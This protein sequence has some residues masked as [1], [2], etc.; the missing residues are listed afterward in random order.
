MKVGVLVIAT[1]R[2][3]EL[4]A[5][6]HASMKRYLLAGTPHD[7]RYF[8]FTDAPAALAA[9]PGV[10]CIE[11][12]WRPW[13]GPSLLRY[14]LFLQHERLLSEVDY[15]LH[16][17]AD[18]RFVAP[19][20][21]E[22]LGELVATISPVAHDKRRPRFPYENRVASAAYVPPR[23]GKRYYAGAFN[24]GETGRFLEMARAI[25][26]MTDADGRRGIV[27]RCNDES[28]LNKYL[29]DHPPTVTLSP[30]YCYPES[31]RLPFTPKVLCL[32]KNHAAMRSAVEKE[33][34]PKPPPPAD[35]G[36][37]RFVVVV[38]SY[39]NRPWVE[40]CLDSIFA[41]DHPRFRVSYHDDLSSDG[42]ADLVESY[43]ARR[44]IGERLSLVRNRSKRFPAG[45]I[46]GAAHAADDDEIVVTLDGDDCFAHPGVL[47]HLDRLYQDPE[48][49]LTYGQF[50][51]RGSKRVG[52]AAPL[53]A[54]AIQRNA[55]RRHPWV[56][57]HLRT[58][59][60]WLYKRIKLHDLIHRGNFISAAGDMALMLPMAEMA[61]R[62]V[63]FVPEVLYV[64]NEG[65]PLSDAKVHRVEQR[66]CDRHVRSRPPYSPLAE[67]PAPL[68]AALPE[69]ALVAL[70]FD[71]PL[72]LFALLE[73]LERNAVQL[74]PITVIARA[75]RPE[76]RASYAEV[77][78]RFP[79]VRF[80]FQEAAPHDFAK[81]VG[82]A[83]SS[84]GS[85]HVVFAVDDIVVTRPIAFGECARALDRTGA[86]G[87][88]L[89]M[90]THLRR[91]YPV[92]KPQSVPPYLEA[93]PGV[94]A[95][96][97]AAGE[98][99]WRYP[100]TLDMTIYRTQEIR[101][102]FA[103]LSFRSPN[104]LEAA[105]ARRARLDRV[106]LFFAE[107]R[108][109]NLPLNRVQ[110]DFENRAMSTLTAEDLL[111][112]FRAGLKLDI[113]PLQGVLNES[114]HIDY[115]PRFVPR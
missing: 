12:P 48:V 82:E 76:H 99:D 22:I 68:P 90:G 33:P 64:Y 10:T 83:V 39:N 21:E 88:F 62:R 67:R 104:T 31:W 24:G 77:G 63:R 103:A 73:S 106:G 59:Y 100:N 18:M 53:P 20:G 109:V 80:L 11:E 96:E 19:V 84:A 89:R 56:L 45:N 8:V 27:A 50:V 34:E 13:P 44:G 55:L 25:R 32:D 51:Y 4:V 47:A 79:A 78:Q 113:A 97:F 98:L 107:A 115:E 38:P 36:P 9:S 49:W 28:Y 5:P 70:T 105:W 37:R 15:L 26:D 111:D 30:E 75:S 72:Q 57:T 91:S 86:H 40:E 101:A 16:C 6:L 43:V 2:Y 112:R 71:R 42:T 1:G 60:A 74:G 94:L 65:N 95:W 66:E 110:N 14:H 29:C 23:A 69:V 114:A 93:L 102:A 61:A 81:L 92:N 85:P 52:F 17:D 3:I 108:V 46:W 58:A 54:A 41:Q 35:R 87:F 7:V